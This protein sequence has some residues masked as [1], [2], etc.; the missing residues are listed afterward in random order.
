MD[1]HADLDLKTSFSVARLMADL[2]SALRFYSRLPGPTFGFEGDPH[3]VPDFRSLP[4]ILPL[5]GFLI[6]LPSALILLLAGG[7]GLSSLPLAALAVATL[8]IT[9][10]AMAEDGFSDVADGFFGGSTKERRLEIMVDSRVGAFGVSALV[11]ALILRVASLGALNDHQGLVAA[12]A[13]LLAAGVLSRVAGVL[14][15]V[16][17][18]PARPG[19]KSASVGRPGVIVTTIAVIGALSLGALCL[20]IGGVSPRMIS[21]ALLLGLASA[22]P[23]MV[24]AQAKIGG[25]TGDV[26]GA[27]QQVAEIV[28]L[29]VLSVA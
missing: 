24:L 20:F 6:A 4:R 28:V 27:T 17:L 18:P 11:L 25:Q 14:P 15:L 8:V 9:T 2:L 7:V 3:R 1:S 29:L 10:G 19:G 13:S 21:V 23:V 5:A 26:A 16:F 22:F 12:S